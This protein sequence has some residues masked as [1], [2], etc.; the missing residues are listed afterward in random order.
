[1]VCRC[2]CHHQKRFEDLITDITSV[3]P[4]TRR[5]RTHSA[6]TEDE[7]SDDEEL[8]RY[9]IPEHITPSTPHQPDATPVNDNLLGQIFYHVGAR[10]LE[11]RIAASI[12]HATPAKTF[13][14]LYNYLFL[15]S[16]YLKHSHI[17]LCYDAVNYGTGFADP[18][19]RHD[20]ELEELDCNGTTHSRAEIHLALFTYILKRVSCLQLLEAEKY[21]VNDDFSTPTDAAF[22]FFLRS[23]LKAG[24]FDTRV[25][26]PEEPNNRTSRRL[27]LRPAA[28]AAAKAA[29]AE[30]TAVNDH[31]NDSTT[32]KLEQSLD[33]ATTLVLSDPRAIKAFKI[34]TQHPM[35]F[36][37]QMKVEQNLLK[38]ERCVV[39][40]TDV[41]PKGMGGG[42]WEV[43]WEYM[44]KWTEN[45]LVPDESYVF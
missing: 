10:T 22:I 23:L 4:I 45:K 38:E 3:G 16:P 18:C 29:E 34:F 41:G 17:C 24:G 14:N 31:Y 2:P 36:K 33:G 21:K 15:S 30:A 19:G 39:W 20:A 8:P 25:S 1:M 26:P 35:K 27:A 12:P 40:C 7:Y 28:V 13:S 43:Q 9:K 11:A 6:L 37:V 5:K 42:G 32:S 44:A